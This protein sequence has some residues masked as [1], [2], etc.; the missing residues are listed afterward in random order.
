M[1]CLLRLFFY[2]IQDCCVDKVSFLF[3]NLK[4][5]NNSELLVFVLEWPSLKALIYFC[6]KYTFN[7]FNFMHSHLFLTGRCMHVSFIVTMMLMLDDCHQ[8]SPTNIIDFHLNSFRKKAFA[9]NYAI[10]FESLHL[11]QMML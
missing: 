3:V 9:K 8:L 10:Y 11:T 4:R 5:R 2:R 7:Q 6:I 1:L